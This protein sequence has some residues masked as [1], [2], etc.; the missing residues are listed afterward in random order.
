MPSLVKFRTDNRAEAQTFH[1]ALDRKTA[2][3]MAFAGKL[4]PPAGLTFNGLCCE[5]W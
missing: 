1:G 2:E 5:S 3:M 4:T